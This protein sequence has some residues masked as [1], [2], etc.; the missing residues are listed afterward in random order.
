VNIQLPYTV[1][2]QDLVITI[3]DLQ[4]SVCMAKELACGCVLI[5]V[6]EGGKKLMQ[7]KM[8]KK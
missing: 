5:D 8:I 4:V 7:E 3:Y 2:V 1:K 6:M